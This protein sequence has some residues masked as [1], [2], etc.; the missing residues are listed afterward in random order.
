MRM[1]NQ[2]LREKLKYAKKKEFRMVKNGKVLKKTVQ[3][4]QRQ[5][6][7]T[8]HEI[9]H[10]A[11]ATLSEKEQLAVRACFSAAKLKNRRGMRYSR[12]WLYECILLRIRSKK[13]YKHLRKHKILVLPSTSTLE[14]SME[15]IKSTYGFQESVFRALEFKTKQMDPKDVHRAILVDEMKLSTTLHFNKMNLKF[16]GF[17]NLGDHHHH[18]HHHHRSR[19]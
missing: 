19:L 11:I 5:C 14:R 1:K 12:Q 17:T 13:A 8:K 4:L 10:G 15:Q 18:H 9:L 3:Q 6:A 2:N 16:K 7:M